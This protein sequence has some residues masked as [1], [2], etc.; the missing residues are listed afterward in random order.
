MEIIY[1]LKAIEDISYWK[2]SGNKAV[3][4]KIS[5]LPDDIVKHPYTGIG[6]PEALKHQLSGEPLSTN[7]LIRLISESKG[8]KARIWKINK[9]I[10]ERVARMGDFLH[11]PLNSER[12]NTK[13]V[14]KYLHPV[15]I[16]T[17][18]LSS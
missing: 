10:I 4:E 9:K 6:K 14:P 17:S 7:Q 11:L 5:A 8:R 13:I 12:L 1:S 2:K 16:K 18:E 3:Q 15:N